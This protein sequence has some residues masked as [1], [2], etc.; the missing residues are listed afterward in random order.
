VDHLKKTEP[1]ADLREALLN[2]DY[3][4]S[5][6]KLENTPP[7]SWICDLIVDFLSFL[8]GSVSYL[9][10]YARLLQPSYLFL[11]LQ[12]FTDAEEF[13]LHHRNIYDGV[14][15]KRIADFPLNARFIFYLVFIEMLL[16]HRHLTPLDFSYSDPSKVEDGILHIHSTL[17]FHPTQ[18]FCMTLDYCWLLGESL[19]H[20]VHAG[21]YVV[22]G[23]KY[24]L[25]ARFFLDYCIEPCSEESFLRQVVL[26]RTIEKILK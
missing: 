11:Y 19:S 5:L 18:Y 3:I 9:S 16:L 8:K 17:W 13:Y 1:S 4:T 26:L 21:K 15:H 22:D 23:Q 25:A 6:I 10:P 12:K 24:A 2:T 7:S 20:P 14:I